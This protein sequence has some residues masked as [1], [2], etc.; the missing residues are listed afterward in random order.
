MSGAWTDPAVDDIAA[1][2]PED[3]KAPGAADALLDRA[4][5]WRDER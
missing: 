3:L 4:D 1:Y 5:T 2:D